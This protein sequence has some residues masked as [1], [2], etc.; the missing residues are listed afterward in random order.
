MESRTQLNSWGAEWGEKGFGKLLRG[1]NT[2]NIEKGEGALAVSVPEQRELP[3]ADAQ[4]CE[5]GGS[6]DS[7]CGCQCREGFA[8][9]R[10]EQCAIK[11]QH[12]GRANLGS[13]K[14]DCTAGYFGEHCE[15]YVLGSWRSLG[16]YPDAEIEFKW[17]LSAAQWHG[18]ATLSRHA[19]TRSHTCTF[20]FLERGVCAGMQLSRRRCASAERLR[21]SIRDR[22]ACCASFH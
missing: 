21:T 17:Q 13:C 1:R 19:C 8:G 12:F 9:A 2:L 5:N 11:C 20:L 18:K 3:C 7:S 22:A 15:N 14:C 10:C 16:T 4:P 6:L